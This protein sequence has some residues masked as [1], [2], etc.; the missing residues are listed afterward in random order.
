MDLIATSAAQ[1]EWSRN[2]RRQGRVIGLVPTM[3]ALH[4]GHR[5]LIEIARRQCDRV[6]V[7]LFVN[8]TQFGPTEDLAR[9]PRPFEADADLCRSLGVAALFHPSPEAMYAPDHSCFITDDELTRT[10]CGPRRPGH[11]RGVLTV[12]AKLF[13]IVLPDL[14]VFGQ[15]D[16]QQARLIER[17]VRDLNFPLRLIVA[18]TVREADGLALS[19]RNR[20][21]SEADRLRARCVPESLEVGRSLYASG[22]RSAARLREGMLRRL[23]QTPDAHLE[24]LEIVD[25]RTLQPVDTADDQ[26]VAAIALKI[27]STRLIDN[28]ILSGRPP[29]PLAPP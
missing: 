15:K 4:D 27:G 10:L 14:A 13:N 25:G 28:Q 20:Y 6:V 9:Y 22:I 8:P 26:T 11:F 1:Q 5:S 2:Q 12:V 21:L 17:M 29:A 3:G 18:P 24:Y 16:F 23:A 7:S 19:S